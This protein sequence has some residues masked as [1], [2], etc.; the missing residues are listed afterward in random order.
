M[1]DY[2]INMNKVTMS[3]MHMLE[4][5]YHPSYLWYRFRTIIDDKL[6]GLDLHITDQARKEAGFRLL[7]NTFRDAKNKLKYYVPNKSG[8]ETE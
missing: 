6:Y 1:M 5:D 3:K 4:S 8:E 7:L 2:V